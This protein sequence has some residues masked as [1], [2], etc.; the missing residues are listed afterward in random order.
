VVSAVPVALVGLLRAAPDS[1]V[2]VAVWVNG[3]SASICL[4]LW[5]ESLAAQ[6]WFL[7]PEDDLAELDLVCPPLE[8]LL[9]V[10]VRV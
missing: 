8:V 3:L 5:A 10:P 7:Q 6:V 9:P 2:A 4:V 1:Q